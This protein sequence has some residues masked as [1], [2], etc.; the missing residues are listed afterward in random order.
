[1]YLLNIE[2]I[3][4]IYFTP[5][6]M[7]IISCILNVRGVKKIAS[8]LS[9]SPR[10]V[11]GHIQNILLKISSNSQE[12]IKDFVE[13]SE[14]ISQLKNYYL[15]LL[16]TSFLIQQLKKISPLFIR[17][18]IACIVHY[19][20]NDI[21]N[22]IIK[23]LKLANV[24]VIISHNNYSGDKKI[25][26]IFSDETSPESKQCEGY[27]NLIFIC[28]D[29]TLYSNS[30]DKYSSVN[31]IDCSKKANIH[32]GIFKI[33]KIL[34]PNINLADSV[35]EFNKLESNIMNLGNTS[36]SEPQINSE[37]NGL[38]DLS[39]NQKPD[40][41]LGKKSC[42]ISIVFI[43]IITSLF[44]FFPLKKIAYI[45][46]TI[47]EASR[48]QVTSNFSLLHKSILLE[49]P[50]MIA[51]IQ[52]AFKGND[53]IETVVLMGIG[54]VGKTTLARQYITNQTASIAWEINAETENSLISSIEQLLYALCDSTE[55]RA[56]LNMLIDIKDPRQ[57]A[58]QF[59]LLLQQKLKENPNW[60]LIYD[61]VEA[62]KYIQPYFPCNTKAWGSGRIIITTKDTNIKNNSYIKNSNVI[63]VEELSEEEKYQLFLSIAQKDERNKNLYSDKKVLKEFL[64]QIPSFPLDVSVAAYYLKE[65]GVEYDKYLKQIAAPNLEFTALQ[66]NI[67]RNTNEY[68][69][70]RYSI[71]VLSIKQIITANPDFKELLLF[72]SLL[73]S[74]EIS[75]E[76]LVAYKN[77]MVVNSFISELKKNSFITNS[78]STDISNNQHSTFSMH[79]SAQ[80][81][82]LAYLT[83]SINLKTEK[84]LLKSITNA[85]E[86]YISKLVE[87]E[88]TL[89]LKVLQNHC[90]AILTRVRD[91]VI[92]EESK[93]SIENALGVI[94]YYI[95]DDLK[96]RKILESSLENLYTHN[97]QTSIESAWTLLHLGAIYRKLGN[98]EKSIDYLTQSIA[99]YKTF[100]KNNFGIAMA[101]THLGNAYRSIGQFAQAK[102]ALQNSIKLS[103]EYPVNYAGVAKA[104]VY[105]GSLYREEGDYKNAQDLLEQSLEIYNTHHYPQ[106]SSLHARVL[107]HLGVVYRMTGSYERARESLQ[108][109]IDIYKKIRPDNHLD[110]NMSI[111]NLG[112]IYSEQGDYNMAKELLN[113]SIANYEIYYGKNH[114]VIGKALNNLG[115]V[116]ILGQNLDMASDTLIR[117]FNILDSASHPESY[118]ALELLSDIYAQ[119]T[120]KEL[121]EKGRTLEYNSFKSKSI[122]YLKQS[123]RIAQQHFSKDSFNIMRVEAKITDSVKIEN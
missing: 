35:R 22:Y 114:I 65:T 33:L 94:S 11:E 110:V 50:S 24:D 101:L 75:K 46:N 116:Y 39:S 15:D 51:R 92:N 16:I 48:L 79:R 43:C 30:L 63:E 96:A 54:G 71:M 117:A 89:K 62:F 64:E 95:G 69:K 14:Q 61:N 10:T 122:N 1:M 68:S 72:I 19:T 115:R 47:N 28:N 107:S 103:Q 98:Y 83:N 81:I 111:L 80:S 60:L 40:S 25:P 8:I 120:I 44:V 76:L 119:K 86:S 108:K 84:S 23:Y 36:L 9:I 42:I 53:T 82:I 104:S 73:N 100:P 70:T 41:I 38:L 109:S 56:K 13:R 3:N 37:S 18:K 32:A 90:E 123:L 55:Q 74:R 78:D 45:Y 91:D 102:L 59:I 93:T 52:D 49:R 106:Y 85:I 118:R 27:K 88:D 34:A 31:L 21:L 20:K 112:I 77:D 17:N 121:K 29:E 113:K 97:R 66:E 87:A 6:E 12:H 7:E 57:R 99:I 67:L 105:L 4:G 26:I 58:N 5:R 2:F